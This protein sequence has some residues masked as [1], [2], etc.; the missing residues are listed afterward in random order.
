MSRIG[1]AATQAGS[2][3][4]PAAPAQAGGAAAA[5]AP[6][7]KAGARAPKRE[8]SLDQLDAPTVEEEVSAALYKES[9]DSF[10]D[11]AALRPAAV[12]AVLE[13]LQR[14]LAS[15]H[16]GSPEDLFEL[17]LGVLEDELANAERLQQI[18]QR[19]AGR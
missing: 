19:M 3:M 7:I 6:A 16:A 11:P 1:G 14:D 13:E 10:A 4:R 5:A 9:S 12:R 15:M 8:R 2:E 18:L 17:G